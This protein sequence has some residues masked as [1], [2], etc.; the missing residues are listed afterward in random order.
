MR[1]RDGWVNPNWHFLIQ[2][3]RLQTMQ[4]PATVPLFPLPNQVLLI[5]VPTTYRVFEPRYRALIDDLLQCHSSEQRW[6]AIP[7]LADGWQQDYYGKP[8]IIPCA[9]L[10]VARSIRPSAHGEFEVLIEGVTRCRL[11][12]IATDTP[13][14]RAEVTVLPDEPV[15]DTQV[16]T[17][18]QGLLGHL[19]LILRRMGD[20]AGHLARLIDEDDRDPALMVDRL[21]AVMITDAKARRTFLEERN[22]IHRIDH[23]TLLMHQAIGHGPQSQPSEN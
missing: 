12:E 13:Y 23:L 1:E 8:A 9:A 18:M 15:D 16:S 2:V 22:V 5:G 19:Q 21:A 20:K 3:V 10:A 17:H 11:N 6:L 4:Y 14:R 7:T